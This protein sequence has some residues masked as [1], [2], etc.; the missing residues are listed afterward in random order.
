TRRLQSFLKPQP[1]EIACWLYRRP[2]HSTPG[3]PADLRWEQT[4][5]CRT[6]TSESIHPNQSG[7]VCRKHIRPTRDAER[8]SARP[9]VYASSLF[10]ATRVPARRS[11]ASSPRGSALAHRLLVLHGRLHSMSYIK[12]HHPALERCARR[13]TCSATQKAFS[14]PRQ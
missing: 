7:D 1:I 6:Q 2:S 5:D 10:P 12:R 8:G 4:L 9:L 14:C 3:L 11:S 13:S